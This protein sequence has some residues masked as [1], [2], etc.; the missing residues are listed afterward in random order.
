RFTMPFAHTQPIWFYAPMLL[1]GLLPGSLLLLP[2]LRFLGSGREEVRRLRSSEM[3]FMVLAGM[4][5]VL[6]F[7]LSGCKLPTYI[8]PS[9]PFL[10]LALGHFI[11]RSRR[12][13]S[14]AMTVAATVMLGVLAAGNFAVIPWIA[15][16]RSPMNQPEEVS[17]LCGDR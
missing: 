9:F 8:L 4:W 14:Q 6:F 3:G 17:A 13:Q 11:A 12:S 2:L 10:A 15:R 1:A 16:V 5:C 7:S